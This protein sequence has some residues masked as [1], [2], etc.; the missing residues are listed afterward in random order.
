MV[1]SIEQNKAW[2]HQAILNFKE[3]SQSNYNLYASMFVVL[4]MPVPPFLEVLSILYLEPFQ[5]MFCHEPIV[6]SLQLLM[7]ILNFLET[8]HYLLCAK[9]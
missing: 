2:F 3:A 6:A 4:Y 8:C 5:G 1:V 7:L 9:N